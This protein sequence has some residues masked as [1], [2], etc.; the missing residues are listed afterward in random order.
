MVEIPCDEGVEK[1]VRVPAKRE[2]AHTGKISNDGKA[3]SVGKNRD[4]EL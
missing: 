1:K 4:R 3:C 2:V